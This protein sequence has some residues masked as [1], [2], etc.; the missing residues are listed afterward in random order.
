M[1]VRDAYRGVIEHSV[2]VD[3]ARHGQ[4]I[5]AT[6]LH[7]FVIAADDAGYWMI[8]SSIFPENQASLHL[9]E[10]VGFRVVGTRQQIARSLVGPHAG[11]WRDTVLIERR[12]TRNGKP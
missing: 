3:T 7:A 6:L 12:S 2:Y 9:H 5:G 4:G 8:Q 10:K 1:S 11:S